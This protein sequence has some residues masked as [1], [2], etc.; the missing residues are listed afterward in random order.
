MYEEI[1]GLSEHSL[2]AAGVT[3]APGGSVTDDS[4]VE[5]LQREADGPLCPVLS[6]GAGNFLSPAPT[7]S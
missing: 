5:S 7:S 1:G 3:T 6:P 4:A 2:G